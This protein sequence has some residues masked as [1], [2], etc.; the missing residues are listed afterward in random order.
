MYDTPS[1][2]LFH[3]RINRRCHCRR[4]AVMPYSNLFSTFRTQTQPKKKMKQLFKPTHGLSRHPVHYVWSAVKSRCYNQNAKLY[5]R[6]GGR[7]ITMCADWRNNFIAFYNWMIDNGWSKGLQIDRI[8]NNGNY[9]PTN[10][11]LVSSQ[12]NNNNKS[13]NHFITCNGETKTLIQWSRECGVSYV[14]ILQR[15]KTMSIED[16]LRKGKIKRKQGKSTQHL[17]SKYSYDTISEIR[18]LF[19]N[20]GISIRQISRELKIPFRTVWNIIHNRMR[21]NA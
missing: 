13:T 19:K 2:A 4:T 7:G 18:K 12:V 3:P 21:V 14:T 15:M 5:H 20:D 6:Y 9:E 1:N 17:T 16:A 10:C 11:R 8:D